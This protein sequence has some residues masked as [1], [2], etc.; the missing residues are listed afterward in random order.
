MKFTAKNLALALLIS[1]AIAI[2]AA[3]ESITWTFDDTTATSEGNA[4]VALT[5]G[6][7]L[8]GTF[9]YNC[10]T[11]NGGTCDGVGDT[12]SNP[13]LGTFSNVNVSVSN[14]TVIAGSQTWYLLQNAD[15]TAS[16]A[17]SIFLV[18]FNPTY[19]PVTGD[20]TNGL[21]AGAGNSPGYLI[22]LS[23]SKN[24][25]AGSVGMDD[26]GGIYLLNNG[27]P[28]QG[29]YCDNAE[30]SVV[31]SSP[32]FY[33]NALSTAVDPTGHIWAPAYVPP[34]SGIPEPATMALA[35]SALLALGF[36]RRKL[37]ARK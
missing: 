28:P 11:A 14:G 10:S 35:G 24:L 9:T 5:G 23:I 12:G 17:Q 1:G 16:D 36:A 29:G 7:Q 8:T 27:A 3:A 20:A 34:V 15:D 31:N 32:G 4:G 30:C 21:T 18:N 25:P 19:D 37:S 2:P 33:A 22:A 13:S 26:N 6:S